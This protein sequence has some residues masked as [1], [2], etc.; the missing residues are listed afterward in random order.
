MSKTQEDPMN[1][2]QNKTRVIAAVEAMTDAFHRGD[3]QGVMQSYE[4]GATVAFEPGKSVSGTENIRAAFLE[5]FHLKPRFRYSGHDVILAGDTATHIAPWLMQATAPDG[6]T[7]T[8][9]GLSVAVLRKQDDG[10][11]L[12]IM[13]TPHGQLLLDTAGYPKP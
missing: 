2:D 10:R 11:W 7:I 1:I 12:M 5:F 13:D 8:Q 3:I 4:S 6:T 9:R